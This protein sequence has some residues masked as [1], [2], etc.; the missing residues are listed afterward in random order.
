MSPSKVY[1]IDST[2]ILLYFMGNR[3]VAEIIDSILEERAVGYMLEPCVAELFQR[4]TQHLGYTVAS[5]RLEA[6]RNSNIRLINI[7]FDL[8]KEAGRIKA[9]NPSI[10]MLY[11]YMIA[12][13]KRFDAVIVTADRNIRTNECKIEYIEHTINNLS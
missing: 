5:S 9:L 11:A 10:P 12:L 8:I 7:D 13:A 4:L 1:V 3:R 6:I 2:A